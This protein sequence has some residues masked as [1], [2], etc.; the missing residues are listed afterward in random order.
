MLDKSGLLFT[1]NQVQEILNTID[2]DDTGTLDF[3]ECL[4]VSLVG[5]V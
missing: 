3:M 2:T 4:E 5:L 1:K